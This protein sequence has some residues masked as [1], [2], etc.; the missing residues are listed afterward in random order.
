MVKSIIGP[1]DTCHCYVHAW[2]GYV[3]ILQ[4]STQSR[5]PHKEPICSHILSTPDTACNRTVRHPASHSTPGGNIA[6]R[7]THN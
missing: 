3:S 5:T 4:Y 2:M 1:D 7:M 6:Y